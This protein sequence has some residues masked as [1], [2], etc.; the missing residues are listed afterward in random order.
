MELPLSH[1]LVLDSSILKK[2][3]GSEQDRSWFE[4]AMFFS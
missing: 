3:V 1:L 2:N 4:M